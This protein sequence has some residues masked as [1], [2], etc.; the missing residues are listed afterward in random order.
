M[1]TSDQNNF[2]AE[3]LLVGNGAL[4]AFAANADFFAKLETA[5][6]ADYDVAAATALRQQLLDGTFDWPVIEIVDSAAIAGAQGAYVGD[7]GTILL[8]ASLFTASS[9]SGG[10]VV[11]D[12]GGADDGGTEASTPVLDQVVATLLEEF[13]HHVDTIVNTADAAGDEGAIFSSLVR[14]ESLS[15]DQLAALQGENDTATLTIDG[16]AMTAELSTLTRTSPTSGG[17]VPA[18]VTEVG[19]LVLDM[20]GIN[21]ARVI[22]QLSAS[23]LYEGY[24]SSNP[25]TI[26]TQGGFSATVVNALGGGLQ[27]VAVRL[28]VLDGDTSSGNF[29]FNQNTLQLNGVAMG[30]FSSVPTQRTSSD[31]LTVISNGTGFGN[32]TLDTGWFHSTNATFL[33]NFY[34][35]LSSGSVSFQLSDTDPGDNYFDFSAGVDG[36]LVDVGQPP[37]VAPIISAVSNSGPVDEGDSATITVTASDP[38]ATTGGLT[39]EFDLDNNG[40][41]EVSN[42]TGTISTAVFPD[43]GNFTIN[44]R[45]S[46]S[47]GG[48]DLDTTTV[49]VNNVA[50]VL[51]T[52]AVDLSTWTQED[53]SAGSGVWTVA[54]GGE[55]V[56]QSINGNPTVFYS[57]VSISGDI[58]GEITVN[59]A[60]DDDFVGFVLGFDPGELSSATSDYVLIDWKQGDQYYAGGWAYE[61]L[62][63]SHVT[64]ALPNLADPWIHTGVV[65]EIARANTLGSTG[66]AD[67]APNE[68][69]FDYDASNL[70][71]FVNGTLEFDLDATD[72]GGALPQGRLGFY[73]FSQGN[74]TYNTFSDDTVTGVEGTAVTVTKDFTDVGVLDSHTATINWGDGTIT[75]GTVTGTPGG[76][77]TINGSHVY[78]D[79]GAYTVTVTVDDG[80]G[81]SDSDTLTATIANVAPTVVLNGITAID[82]N[83]VATLTGTIT[84]PGTLDTFTLDIDWGDALSP[85]NVE[86]YNFSASGTGSQIF[87]LTHQYL[88]DNPTGTS[89]DSYTI[90]ATVT[91]DDGGVGSD[92]ESVQVDNVAPEV[93]G[94]ALTSSINENDYATLSGTIVDPGTLDSFTLD[95]DWG[96]GGTNSIALGNTALSGASFGADLVTWDPGTGSY[97]IDH[98]YLDDNPTGTPSDIYEVT[99]TVTDDD[100]G[101]GNIGGGGS[102]NI[103]FVSDSSTDTNIATVLTGDGYSVTTVTGDYSTG[104]STL[105][106]SLGGYDAVYWSATGA[107]YGSIHTDPAVF[108]NLS[109]YVS[110]GGSVFVTGYDSVSSP[111]DAPLYSFLGAT[112][113]VDTPYADPNGPIINVSNSLTTG[114]V[115]IRGVLATGGW[116][117]KDQL[118]LGSGATAVGVAPSYDSSGGN[119][120][121]WT[122]KSFG[123]GEIAYVSNGAHNGTGLDASWTNTSA[124]GAGAYNAAL[125]NFAAAADGGG[126]LEVTVNNVDP[127]LSGLGAMAILENGTTTLSGSIADVGTLD[128]FTV[129]IDWDGNGTIDETHTGLSAGNFSYTHQYLDDNPTGTAVDLMPI[130]VIVTDDDGGSDAGGTTVEVTNVAP[131]LAFDPVMAIDENGV[132][133][134]TGTITD[135]GTLDTFTLAINWGDGLSPDNVES[136]SFGA[137]ATGSQTFTLTHQY[138]DDNPTATASDTYTINATVTDDD[139]GVGSDAETVLVRNVDP[140]LS[141]LAAT[142]I[143]ENGT[144]TLSGSIADVGTLDTFTVEIDWD[145]NGTIDETHTGLSAGNFSYTHQYLDDNPTGTAVDLMPINVIVTDDDGGSDAGGTTVEVTNVAPELAFDP[146][147]AID[148]NGVATLTGTITDPGT[149][150]TF[151]LAINWGDGL[152]PDNVESYSFGASATG[153]QT[154]T[155]THQYLDDNPTATASDTY[156]INATVTDDDTGAGSASQTVL[157]NNVDPTFDGPLVISA[158]R[159][160]DT[161]P[162]DVVSLSGMF[163]DTGSL[164]T[165]TV[166]I[167]WGDG[168]SSNSLTDPGDFVALSVSGGGSGAFDATHA[169]GTGGIFTVV[170]TVTDDDSGA[171]TTSTEAWVSGVRLDPTTGEL[172]IVGTTDRDKVDV[173]ARAEHGSGSGHG[174]GHG[175]GSGSGHGSGQGSGKGKGSGS[176]SGHGSGHGSG[177]GSGGFDAMAD[178][179]NGGIGDGVELIV[180]TDFSQPKTQAFAAEDV[181]SIRIVLCQDDDKAKIHSNVVESATIEGDGGKDKL[182]GGRGDD[183]ILGGGGDDRLYGGIGDDDLRGGDDNDRLY[184]DGGGSGSGHGSGKG[185]GKG[186]GSGH[187]SGS[188]ASVELSFNDYLSGG[189]G[190][191]KLFGQQ[192]DDE[193]H[194]DDGNDQLFGGAGADELFGGDDDDLLYGD[195]NGGGSGSGS[196]HGS[197]HGSGKGHGSG[198]G[199]DDYLDGGDGQDQLF[200][201][202]GDDT[203]DG[204]NGNDL[205]NGGRGDDTLIG[206][207]GDDLF[208]FGKKDDADT[209]LDF[210]AGAGTDDVV[211]LSGLKKMKDLD[212]LL[213]R[214]DDVG[215]DTVIDFGKGD[216]LTL[217][218]VQKADLHD[219][220][221]LF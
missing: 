198:S 84:D 61:G 115:D 43:D 219:D 151:T 170:V 56:N 27:E 215:A 117:D 129:E 105:L 174:S 128:T 41:Y 193:L 97:S 116:G 17:L 85:G 220:D 54:P 90:N 173:R 167:D 10:T 221:F 80:D 165:H 62:A 171:V 1:A 13:G 127:T 75:A 99:G 136:Y 177:L 65:D 5:F 199:A 51:D 125:R 121:Q 183:L 140:T 188:G 158:V 194:G 159:C 100:G 72:F 146:V 202:G 147:M 138:L 200:G 103:L 111:D 166:N 38:D 35:S 67:N 149:L 216:T 25:G 39:Y 14:D 210:T 164:D 21:G 182:N 9:D 213:D 33:N 47:R 11:A 207:D 69:T 195:S 186:S 214:A 181:D 34:N 16:E 175:S 32:G 93:M 107:G 191:D 142:A 95:L 22:S 132:A 152:S 66:W 92:S 6:G 40:S 137:S 120:W 49:V 3:A 148:E 63:V 139:T 31:G 23:S 130:N 162:E 114:V 203:L 178:Y 89:T 150:D 197:G 185:S 29:D 205:L 163:L 78:E 124:G 144:T 110:D 156:T 83:G 7:S 109:N 154:F 94:G 2:V 206:G 79:N 217:V 4:A 76:A 87:T 160:S 122:L 176:G 55:T 60:S 81:G 192:G 143:L 44:V 58:Q 48:T 190:N 18:G 19:G 134:L 36:G 98:Q 91:D 208:Q 212:D 126:A 211:E 28:T 45:V 42:T 179:L 209:I 73:N 196:G 8:S 145:G 187:G 104:N 50:P 46:D 169:Y 71:I 82:E 113:Q 106:G 155:L 168:T 141:G 52:G 133:T 102:G 189:N 180:K 131:E 161:D 101:V 30:N 204:G 218:G 15:E 74:V 24:F 64:G 153:S 59:T 77:G 26:G 88:D 201:Q 119:G 12:G 37:N 123:S 68:F 57:D 86:S 20:V 96:D 70:R 118:F 157:V 172:Q 135:P 53:F 108:V 112:G 184:G